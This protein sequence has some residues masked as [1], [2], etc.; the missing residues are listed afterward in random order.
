ML[1]ILCFFPVSKV[2]F[3]CL[4][5]R[6]CEGEDQVR[7]GEKDEIGDAEDRRKFNC[8]HSQ[9]PGGEKWE[10]ACTQQSQTNMINPASDSRRHGEDPQMNWFM[11]ETDMDMTELHSNMSSSGIAQSFKDKLYFLHMVPT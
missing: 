8:D 5:Y 2:K 3:Q 4:P 10:K 9:T 11:C 6:T 7:K 1:F